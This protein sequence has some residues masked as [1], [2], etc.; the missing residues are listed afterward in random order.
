MK[1][2]LLGGGNPHSLA[3]AR[4]L[5]SI[6][7]DQFGIGRNSRKPD[8]LWLVP[9]DYRYYQAHIGEQTKKV[10][11]ILDEERPDVICN[12][13]AQG[14]GA[15]SFGESSWRFYQTNVVFLVQLVDE[16]RKRQYLKRFIQI[17]SSE[18]YGST[19]EPAHECAK[20]NPTSPYSASKLCFDQHLQVLYRVH[21]FQMNIVRPS[22]AVCA[23]QQLHRIVPRAAISAVYGLRLK[24]QGGGMARKSF[25][26]TEDLARGILTVLDKGT[27]GEIYNCGPLVPTSI[28]DLVRMTIEQAGAIWDD[29]V[30][31]TPARTGEDSQYW[32]LSSNLRTLGWRP[33]VSMVDA[34][35]RVVEWARAYP[36]LATMPWNYEVTP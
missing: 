32:I 14:E 27:V 3:I 18:I 34:V 17:G 15:A 9:P 24:L 13:A 35:R 28:R 12:I 8:A 4:H 29:V 16:L 1:V 21:G 30:D 10:L 19:S 20:P 33:Q 7:V 26:D 2:A 31:E 22:N 11:E 25:M 23:G 6:G 36:E 5:H